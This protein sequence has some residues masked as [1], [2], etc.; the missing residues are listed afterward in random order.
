MYSVSVDMQD[1]DIPYIQH[2]WTNFQVEYFKKPTFT[3]QL[4]LRSPQI[5]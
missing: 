4:E 1:A 5:E 3:A 2:G